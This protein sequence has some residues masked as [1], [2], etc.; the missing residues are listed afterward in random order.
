MVRAVMF[1]TKRNSI[2]N[3]NHKSAI[4]MM[5]VAGGLAT[6]IPAMASTVVEPPVAD[7]AGKAIV[8]CVKTKGGGIAPCVKTRA[9]GLIPCVKT[10][11]GGIAPCV[12]TKTGE[13]APCVKVKG[14]ATDAAAK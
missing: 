3:K 8:P 9:G 14:L 2:M 7:A 12:K 5:M 1:A 6:A 10:K 4:A 11:G 13:I